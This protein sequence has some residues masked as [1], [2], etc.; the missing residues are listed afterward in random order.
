MGSGSAHISPVLATALFYLVGIIFFGSILA[1]AGV[2]YSTRFERNALRRLRDATQARRLEFENGRG[3]LAQFGLYLAEQLHRIRVR[4]GGGGESSSLPDRIRQ[5]GFRGSTA[6]DAY[7]AARILGPLLGF[8][9][10]SLIPSN[11]G[12]WMLSLP[13]VLYLVPDLLLQHG[14]RRYRKRI[15]RTLPDAVDLLVICVD[16]GLG[17]DQALLRVA[18]ELGLSHPQISSELLQINNEQRAGKPRLEA[19]SDMSKRIDLHDVHALVN[20]LVQTERFGTPISKAL[21]QFAAGLRTRRR[22][23]AE[24]M[25]AKTAV[26]IIFPLVL[27]LL[28]SIFIIM[29]GP[30]VLSILRGFAS[31]SQ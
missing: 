8:I 10:G 17:L 20:M 13:A 21:S 6:L 5:A 28:P 11:R 1:L 24:E 27:F 15:Q 31:M 29:A 2:A 22:Q 23:H 18:E 30:A 3:L 19:W 12:F 9:L 16:A 26:K 7:V 4:A 14:V 25:A